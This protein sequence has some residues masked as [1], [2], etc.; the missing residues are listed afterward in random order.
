VIAYR[1]VETPGRFALLHVEGGPNKV[2]RVV[3]S[4]SDQAAAVRWAREQGWQRYAIAPVTVVV[5]RS[6]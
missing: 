5:P 2:S 1:A 4:F 6:A 3:V